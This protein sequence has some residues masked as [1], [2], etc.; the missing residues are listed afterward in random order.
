[1]SITVGPIQPEALTIDVD[2]VPFRAQATIRAVQ[3]IIIEYL[4]QP[5]PRQVEAGSEILRVH[6]ARLAI[7]FV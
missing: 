4:Q 3:Q 2:F 6:L 7:R 1:M 5:G